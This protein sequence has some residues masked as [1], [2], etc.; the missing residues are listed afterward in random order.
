MHARLPAPSAAVAAP[1]RPGAWFALAA[2]A[3]AL[4][5][6]QYL[7]H[8]YEPSSPPIPEA[9]TIP[10]PGAI[11]TFVSEGSGQP[12]VFVHGNIADLRIWSGQRGPG[13]KGYER[14]TYSRRYHYPNAWAGNG[15]DYTEAN[16]EKDL[17][18]LIRE[19]HLRRV[20]LVG[21]GAGAQLAVE[22]ALSH[23]ELVRTLVL[24]GPAMAAA[25]DGRPGFEALAAEHTEVTRQMAAT[26]KLDE[27]EKAATL[28]FDWVNAKSG[29]YEA[30]PLPSKGEILD[31]AR[32]LPFFLAAPPPAMNCAELGR[33]AVPTLVV[34][35]ERSN[36]FF[37]AVAEAVTACV[38]GAARQTI[39]S[40]GHVVQRENADAFNAALVGFLATH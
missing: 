17:V 8:A 38:P 14:V 24:V 15:A 2:A 35:G 18:S 36:P 1:A 12:I 6:C 39:P 22:V 28:L 9:R 29:S 13:L 31:N 30:L 25:A 5:G 4:G 34:T 26:V 33:L 19:L 3:L 32:V 16:H 10:I 40:A 23:P 7:P 27:D 37:A 21:H 20:H 11:L